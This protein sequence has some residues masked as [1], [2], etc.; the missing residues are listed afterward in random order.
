MFGTWQIEEDAQGALKMHVLWLYHV[1]EV[2]PETATCVP[3][4]SVLSDTKYASSALENS[5]T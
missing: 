3:E 1:S 4:N 5:C 2:R